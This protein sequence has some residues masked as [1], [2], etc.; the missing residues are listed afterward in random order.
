MVQRLNINCAVLKG[1]QNTLRGEECALSM[2]QRSN[3][4][5]S[6]NA[7]IKPGREEYVG[8]TEHRYR[9][10]MDELVKL[11]RQHASDPVDRER[12]RQHA[13]A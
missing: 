3:D 7:Q 5:S 4:A 2:E 8:D 6:S 13:Y 9:Q 12:A 10:Q 11:A 1:A